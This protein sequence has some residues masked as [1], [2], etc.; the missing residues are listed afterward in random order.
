MSVRRIWSLLAAFAFGA[1]FGYL[2][3][4]AIGAVVGV[5]VV[6]AV[7]Y[8]VKAMLRLSAH[9]IEDARRNLKG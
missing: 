9:S 8:A 4:G 3:M 7:P 2:L 6:I 5:A 1:F